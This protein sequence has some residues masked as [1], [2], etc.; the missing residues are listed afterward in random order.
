[1]IW[2]IGQHFLP[3]IFSPISFVFASALA[4]SRLGSRVGVIKFGNRYFDVR[5]DRSHLMNYYESKAMSRRYFFPLPYR[6]PLLP[7]RVDTH[8]Q[9]Y[10]Q[11]FTR[12][13]SE[14]GVS[15]QRSSSVPAQSHR[16]VQVRSVFV[17]RRINEALKA[18]TMDGVKKV[19]RTCLDKHSKG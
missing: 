19:Q 1:M 5:T 2:L 4:Q 11:S 3:P 17:H 9:A 8:N 13:V 15:P 18:D 16:S 10:Q 14:S 7:D 12:S 6:F